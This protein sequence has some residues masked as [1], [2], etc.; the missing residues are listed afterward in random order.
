LWFLGYLGWAYVE[1]GEVAAG[2]VVER[3]LAGNPAQCI[4]S[5]RPWLLRSR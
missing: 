4:A 2:T 3:S 5:A 1:T